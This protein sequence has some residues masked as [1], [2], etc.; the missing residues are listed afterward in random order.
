[1]DGHATGSPTDH[2]HPLE[3]SDPPMV[4]GYPLIGRIGAG[5]MGTVYLGREPGSDARVAV[6]T[7]H[8]HLAADA[9]YRRRFGDEA[10]LAG[11]V[12][13]FCT[14]RV[15]AHGEEDGRPYIVSE[16]VG[17]LSLQHRISANGPLPAAD[18]H[19]VAVGVMSALAAIHSA[20]LVHRDLKPANVML[21]LSGCRVIDFGIARA[22]DAA[23]TLTGAGTVLGTPGWMAPEVLTGGAAGPAADIFAWGCLIAYAG[24]GRLPFGDGQPIAVARRVIRD[25]PDLAAL[26]GT[27]LPAVRSALSKDPER[28][29]SAA[30]LLLALVEQSEIPAVPEPR[31]S[32][33]PS[34]PSRS[35]GRRKGAVLVPE[36]RRAPGGEGPDTAAFTVITHV[37]ARST[38][39]VRLLAAA[40]AAAA[41]LL[42]GGLVAG[43]GGREGGA[44]P[45]PQTTAAS[46]APADPAASPSPSE[47][48]VRR[49]VP[50]QKRRPE[51][52]PKTGA[53]SKQKGKGKAK[54]G[55]GR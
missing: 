17:G 14:A 9:A 36:P 48:P 53:T 15:L 23:G 37:G 22:Q 11:R 54:K 8:P 44:A 45:V 33:R 26:P 51:L 41:T 12:A 24:T 50:V 18:V 19:G 27:L 10:V 21:T 28:R 1:M 31:S 38:T 5:G 42:I 49:A 39:R 55:R 47:A 29:P 20:G 4:G 40:G 35:G 6:K 34:R 43:L 2:A 3:A 16:Y 7:I 30:R 52:R 32:S 13:S 46:P 25:E